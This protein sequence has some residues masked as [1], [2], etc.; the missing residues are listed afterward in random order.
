M[1]NE[2]DY[3]GEGGVCSVYVNRKHRCFCI[4]MYIYSISGD[5]RYSG[6]RMI[7]CSIGMRV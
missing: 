2:M 1:E 7:M 3:W 4:W 6:I 5:E